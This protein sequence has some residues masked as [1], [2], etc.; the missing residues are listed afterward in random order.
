MSTSNPNP[1]DTNPDAAVAEQQPV[2]SETNSNGT[3]GQ[4]QPPARTEGQPPAP[5][6]NGLV[7]LG[8]RKRDR[9]NN[10]SQR[11]VALFCYEPPDSAIGQYVGQLA[12]ALA[13]QELAVHIFARTPFD[14]PGIASHPVGDFSENDIVDAATEFGNRAVEE[15]RKHIPSGSQATLIGHEWSSI[16]ALVQLRLSDGLDSILLLRSLERQRSDMASPI[17][18]RIE[19]V[20]SAGLRDATTILTHDQAAQD[21]ASAWLP[22]CTPRI[23]R[24]REA[25]PAHRF[26]QKLDPG[27]IKAKYQVG[28][29]DPMILFLGDF[30]SRH[31]PDALMRSVPTILKNHQQARFVFAG[32]G[33]LF[34]PL[35]VH[36]RYLLLENAIR[37][38]GSV[39]GK[40][41]DELIQAADMVVVPSREATEWWPI[42]AAWAAGR[43]VVASHPI[44]QAM[45]LRHEENAVL[46]YPH[47]SSL[48]WGIE[49][50]LFDAELQ[51]SLSQKSKEELDTR[52]GWSSVAQQI[53]DL[54]G[55]KQA[56]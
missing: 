10:P 16:P 39:E 15:F 55:V 43:P 41:S 48:V 11:V 22:E 9:R 50:L 18:Q 46:V 54:M 30:D 38:P 20:E 3:A 13:K 35:K 47:E 42:Q 21:A 45:Q 14:L 33:E 12:A 27:E 5:R 8:K 34:W 56:P 26:E 32:D 17:C 36:A 1:G 23:A 44:G 31:G 28:P 4:Q 25:F 7:D 49:R 52:F 6:R 24:L 2:P 51:A 53:C 37:L 19:E 40:A 29:I